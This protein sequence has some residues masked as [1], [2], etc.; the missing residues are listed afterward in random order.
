MVAVGISS[1]PA[2]ASFE[3]T[4]AGTRLGHGEVRNLLT[5]RGWRFIGLC[6]GTQL[7]HFRGGVDLRGVEDKYL[8]FFSLIFRLT[9]QTFL[10]SHIL[11]VLL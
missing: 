9:I 3:H 7:W 8:S 4:V 6:G 5:L 2:F 10:A 1:R 11:S